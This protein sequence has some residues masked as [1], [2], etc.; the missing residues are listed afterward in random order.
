MAVAVPSI[1]RYEL[2]YGAR[3]SVNSDAREQVLGF[4]SF[5]PSLPFD[6]S[7]ADVCGTIRA[8]LESQGLTIGPYDLAIAA[9]AQVNHLTLISHNVREFSRV[10]GLRVEDWEI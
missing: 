5:F 6:D 1:V 10:K 2:V 8:E 4:L 3:R 7:V 9:T